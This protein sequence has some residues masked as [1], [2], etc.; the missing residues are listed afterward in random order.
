M[1]TVRLKI[2]FPKKQQNRP[3]RRGFRVWSL[4]YSKRQSIVLVLV[5]V[6]VLVLESLVRVPS[7]PEFGTRNHSAHHQPDA[8]L[9]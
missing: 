3:R 5:L 2:L 8:K 9:S 1:E 4:G 7:S 6:V